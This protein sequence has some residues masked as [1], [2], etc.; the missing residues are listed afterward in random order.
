MTAS[1]RFFYVVTSCPHCSGVILAHSSTHIVFKSWRFVGALRWTLFFSSFHKFS[2]W[3]K[4]GDW[5]G[6]SNTL[7]FFLWNHLRVSFALCFGSLSCWKVQPRLIFI[8][9][10]DGSRFISRMS[11]YMA[12]F[13][14]P[15]MTWSL[16]VPRDE[17][18]PHAMMFP[19]PNF[20]VGIVLF[21]WCAVPFLLQ[22]WC[23]VWQPKSSILVSSDQTTFSQYWL[24]LS[25][26]CLANFKRASTCLFLRNGVLRAE[27]P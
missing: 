25:K 7:I 12:P 4:S 11:R 1:R 17:K 9:L 27:R 10:V 18:Q 24:G 14:F 19:P 15:S 20:T 16:P 6:H 5:L 26:C 2:I 21:G 22:T 8:I 3:F 23:V 13:I